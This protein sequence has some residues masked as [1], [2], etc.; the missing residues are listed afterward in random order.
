MARGASTE[1]PT[2]AFAVAFG[3][4]VSPLET[5]LV[6]SLM[7]MRT[8]LARH[9]KWEPAVKTL[10]GRYVEGDKC[11]RGP[12]AT[13]WKLTQKIGWTWDQSLNM[14]KSD[15]KIPLTRWSRVQW[16]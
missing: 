7:T 9:A 4:E 16:K 13:M 11:Q 15:K 12:V 14:V 3:R 1:K 6:N 10:L 8:F 2:S 5:G